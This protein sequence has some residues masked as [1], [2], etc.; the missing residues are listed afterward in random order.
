MLEGRKASGKVIAPSYA[1]NHLQGENNNHSYHHLSLRKSGTQGTFLTLSHAF[2]YA[3]RLAN[4]ET[5][6]ASIHV[7]AP[8][9]G[10]ERSIGFGARIAQCYNQLS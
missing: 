8:L 7:G 9:R 3:S 4:G 6:L 10:L 2:T 1:I 5:S